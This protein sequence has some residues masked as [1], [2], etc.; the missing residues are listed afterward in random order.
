MVCPIPHPSPMGIRN[1]DEWLRKIGEFTGKESEVEKVI[2]EEHKIWQPKI[3]AIREQF[4]RLKGN[5]E[6]LT[7]LG[8]LGQG[9]SL[10]E[11]RFFEEIGLSS[12]AAM[13]QD[14]DNLSWMK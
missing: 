1:T 3:D 8:S 6:K 7:V 11:L 12:P 14:F 9:R 13:S 4:L 2:E 5:G 10:A